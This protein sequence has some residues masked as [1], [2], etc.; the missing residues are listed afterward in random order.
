M[1]RQ[2]HHERLNL[3]LYRLKWVA[4]FGNQKSE[5]ENWKLK[6]DGVCNPVTHVSKAIK[7][8]KRFGRGC[9]PRPAPEPIL[10]NKSEAFSLIDQVAQHRTFYELL[11]YGFDLTPSTN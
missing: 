11:R 1:V 9:K 10:I 7:A 8:Y 5:E 2:A 4:E 6:R 3:K